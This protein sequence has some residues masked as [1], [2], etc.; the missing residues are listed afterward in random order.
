MFWKS[1]GTKNR[2][3]NKYVLCIFFLIPLI[4]LSGINL[5]G[6]QN[7]QRIENYIEGAQRYLD[8]GDPEGALFELN[9]ALRMDPKN[10][11]I[12]AMRG[13]VYA[14]QG[15]INLALRIN[16]NDAVTQRNLREVRRASGR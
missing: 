16:P 11:G 5:S 2:M 7:E 6:Y 4:L 10:A 9:R 8:R 13:M 1:V 3:K 15:N 12:Y 14:G